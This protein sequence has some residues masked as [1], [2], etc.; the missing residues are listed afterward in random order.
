MNLKEWLQRIVYNYLIAQFTRDNLRQLFRK[1]LNSAKER[2]NSTETLVDDWAIEA[3]ENYIENDER[4]NRLYE[5]L[6]RYLIPNKDGICMALPVTYQYIG[7]V[8]E[9][10]KPTAEELEKGVKNTC[11]AVDVKFI[12]AV[13]QA[14]I[15]ILI[16]LWQR[17]KE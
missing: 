15:P 13:F 7:L 17:T 3:F 4:F 10:N 2:A 8:E 5:F 14:V 12:V 16:D 6:E 9:L 11:K 1:I